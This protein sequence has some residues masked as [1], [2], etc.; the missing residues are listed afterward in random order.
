MTVKEK[1]DLL[2]KCIRS[3]LR[4]GTQHWNKAGKLLTTDREIIEC[5]LEEGSVTFEPVP[6]RK[7]LFSGYSL[8]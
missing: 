5:M 7:Q 8:Q 4:M 1:A 3:E 6:S 2:L